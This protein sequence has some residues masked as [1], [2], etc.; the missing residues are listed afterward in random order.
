L[1]LC[2]FVPWPLLLLI[3]WLKGLRLFASFFS[4]MECG[5]VLN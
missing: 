2:P 1:P 4:C 3:K 5:Q